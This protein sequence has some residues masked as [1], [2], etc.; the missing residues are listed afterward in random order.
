MTGY[1]IPDIV[2]HY[3]A[4][5]SPYSAYVVLSVVDVDKLKDRVRNHPD[6]EIRRRVWEEFDGLVVAAKIHA[7]SLRVPDTPVSP[8]ITSGECSEEWIT[9]AEA[10]RMLNVDGRTVRNYINR[11]VL[12]AK[13][14]DKKSWL[15]DK[16]SVEEYALASTP[17]A[18]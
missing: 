15:V 18:A 17:K 12:N 13:R 9:V 3:R 6:P 1:V 4:P 7:N 14:K 2:R 8:S 5:V 11:G 16:N 10:S